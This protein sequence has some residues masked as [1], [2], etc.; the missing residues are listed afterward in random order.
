M[1]TTPE[2]LALQDVCR[3]L[4]G[5]GIAYMLTGS[6]AMSY[7][8]RPRMTRDI[9]LVIS[10]DASGVSHL[11]FTL[12]DDYHADATAIASAMHGARP[13]NIIHLPS[14]VKIDLI[15]RKDTDY[16]RTEF[17]RRQLV[18]LAGVALWIV[19]IED[20]ILS[21]LEWSRASRSEQ[22]RGDVKQLLEAPLDRDYLQDWAAR[23]GLRGQLAE[24]GYE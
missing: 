9:D 10:L 23:L 2:L 16:R 8:A 22:Q 6:L 5:A 11:V 15:P 3:R 19:A 13:W 14:M 7:Y 1:T 20:L 12:G 24:A 4:D 17:A 21:K 18:E